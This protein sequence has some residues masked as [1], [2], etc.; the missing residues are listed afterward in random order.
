MKGY[1]LVTTMSNGNA[2][3]SYIFKWRSSADRLAADKT[4]ALMHDIAGATKS[5]ESVEVSFWRWLL[6]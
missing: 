6:L 4:I 2:F 1:R 3:A 5:V